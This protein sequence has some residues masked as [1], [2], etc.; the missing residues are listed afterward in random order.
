MNQ[1][2][3]QFHSHTHVHDNNPPFWSDNQPKP[4]LNIAKSRRILQHSSINTEAVQE[5]KSDKIVRWRRCRCWRSG[6]TDTTLLHHTTVKIRQHL[7]KGCVWSH[8]MIAIV[9]LSALPKPVIS[10]KD[11]GPKVCRACASKACWPRPT[12]ITIAGDITTTTLTQSETDRT[13]SALWATS[14]SS[15]TGSQ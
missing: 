5:C 1:F 10:E 15:T 4:I 11:T 9:K 14:P 6:S 13:S 2:M 7:D 12:R 8:C 3:K